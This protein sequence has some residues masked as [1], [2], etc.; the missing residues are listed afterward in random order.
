MYR[1]KANK[2]GGRQQIAQSRPSRWY[3]SSVSR[4]ACFHD[5]CASKKWTGSNFGHRW[6]TRKNLTSII[7]ALLW[8]ATR[9][10]NASSECQTVV[11]LLV[12]PGCSVGSETKSLLRAW[13]N[14]GRN[15]TDR[16]CLRNLL[17]FLEFLSPF[18]S[19]KAFLQVVLLS[20]SESTLKEF[21]LLLPQF[22]EI[23]RL[24]IVRLA[25][26]RIFGAVG[27]FCAET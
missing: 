20:S 17:L 21:D 26:V 23:F 27:R 6:R 5:F 13:Q 11:K 14:Y 9:L 25:R 10:L 4:F 24:H 8:L 15:V 1:C 7:D 2:I 19:W 18:K 22:Y 16:F 12:L 3:F